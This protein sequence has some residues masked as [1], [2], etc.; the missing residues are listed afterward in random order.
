[1]RSEEVVALGQPSGAALGGF[2]ARI[3][4]MHDGIAKRVFDSLGASSAP[5]KA[6]HDEVAHSVY[7]LVGR[8]LTTA[9]RTGAQAIGAEVAQDGV[10]L[11]KSS[12][13]RIAIGALN[14]AFGDRLEQTGSPLAA[15]MSVR[16]GGEAVEPTRAGLRA[17]FE[18]ATP[19]LAVFLHG[20]CESEE[21]WLL[22]AR[23]HAPYGDRLRSDAGCTALYVRY[24]SGRHI[25]DNG[26]DLAQLLDE[27]I[28][29]WPVEVEEVALIGHSMGGL[30][31]RSA[32]HQGAGMHWVTRVRHVF[33]L[34]TPHLGAPLERA[35]NV[36]SAG[37]AL[38]P[39]TRAMASAL[40][41]RSAGVKDLRYGYLL[42]DD[43]FGHDPD[44]FLRRAAREIPFLAG[45]NHYFVSATL[46][47]DPDAAVGRVIGDLLVLHASAWGHAGRGK[48]LSFPIDNYRHVGS[49]NHFDLLNHPAVYEQIRTWIQGRPALEAGTAGSATQPSSGE[50]QRP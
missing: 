35:A 9:A 20:L 40:N 13:G 32:C 44:A 34:G 1:M 39:E 48:Q 3:E 33:M 23:R 21:A 5:V 50:P 19:R 22:G 41:L 10:S 28:S 16:R 43:W 6:I 30:V 4:E 45:A 42:E 2:A 15:R 37:M 49:A 14:G 46:S 36:V 24:N 17:A 11:E 29:S 18:D 12:R 31:S 7:A 47:G 25:S 38:L 26:R 8:G 27:V